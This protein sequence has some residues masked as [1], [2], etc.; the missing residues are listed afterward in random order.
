VSAGGFS[1]SEAH[2]L[3]EIE[4][5][6]EKGREDLLIPTEELF[7][8]LQAVAL[9]AFYERLCRCGAE[10]YLKK[11]NYSLDLGTRVR[12]MGEK[13]FF[14]LGEVREYPDGTAVKAIKNFDTE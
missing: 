14:A 11:I 4:T 1:L 2:T 6:D 8:D 5:L 9:P 3:E 10:I 7:S 12:L 13:G